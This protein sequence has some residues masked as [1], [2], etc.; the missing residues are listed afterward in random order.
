M[1]KDDEEVLYKPSTDETATKEQ[2]RLSRRTFIIHIFFLTFLIS[3]LTCFCLIRLQLDTCNL[4]PEICEP[5]SPFTPEQLHLSLGANDHEYYV[6]WSTMEPAD[7]YLI[8]NRAS[9]KVLQVIKGE[10]SEGHFDSDV[11]EG[12]KYQKYSYRASMSVNLNT[13]Y[14]YRVVSCVNMKKGDI[15]NSDNSEI[16]G[17]CDGLLEKGEELITKANY[18]SKQYEFLT[19]SFDDPNRTLNLIFYGDLGLLNAQSVP[20]LTKEVENNDLIIHNGDF[21]YDLNTK[22]GKYGDRFMRLMEPIAARIPYQ[23]TVGNHEIAANFSEYNHRF[24]MINRGA[25]NH[26]A[27]NNFFYSFNAGPIHFVAFSTE[28]YYFLER[29]GLEPLV[30][31]WNWLKEDLRHATSEE[32]RAKRPWII[33]FGHRPMYCSSRDN[34]DCSKD[35]NIL[36]RGLPFVGGFALEKLFYDFGVDVEMYSHEHEYERFFPIYDGKFYND[37]LAY[38]NA[39]APAHIISGSAGCQERLDPFNGDH[40]PGSARRISD[41]GYTRLVASRCKL[42]FQQVSDD[43]NGTVVDQFVISKNRQQNFPT[44]G[45]VLEGC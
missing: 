9:S 34:D 26:G 21:A 20:R 33:V 13:K 19:K 12:K 43:Q 41:Y 3:F 32:E 28:F 2:L 11:E 17:I 39:K 38:Q 27:Q 45:P 1:A 31:Q 16:E 8:W 6:T 15:I 44:L 24:T 5:N 10:I 37:S 40:V 4:G 30:D 7:T 25:I 14:Q 22:H 36:R 18:S 42:E 35:S 23:T 29:V